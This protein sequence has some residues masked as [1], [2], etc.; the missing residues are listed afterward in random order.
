MVT[1]KTRWLCLPDPSSES[2]DFPYMGRM[3]KEQKPQTDVATAG[4]ALV[5]RTPSSD[6]V[7]PTFIRLHP[8]SMHGIVYVCK[9]FPLYI[10][11]S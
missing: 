3:F 9:L 11:G 1:C 10:Y 2:A 7:E 6:L 8:C 4:M 5:G